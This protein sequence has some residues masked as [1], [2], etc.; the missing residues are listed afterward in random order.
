M[1][2]VNHIAFSF[3][4]ADRIFSDLSFNV[5]SG[6]IVALVGPSGCGKTTL[7]KLIYGLLP[8]TAGHI[9]WKGDRVPHPN[10]V[11][12]P[13]EKT[14]KLVEQDFNLM[15]FINVYENI[16][17]H[18]LHIHD[19]DRQP[20]LDYWLNFLNITEIE[21]KKASDLSG[22]QM[23][24]V[25][26]AKSLTSNPELI[27]L[28]EPFSNLDTLTKSNL[29]SDLKTHLRQT[30]TTAML[31]I[32]Q[33]EDALEIADKIMVLHAGQIQQFAE[34]KTVYKRP[35]TR[36]V[37]ELFGVS[38][39]LNRNEFNAIFNLNAADYHLID[40]AIMVRAHEIRLEDLKSK[41]DVEDTLFLGHRTLQKVRIQGKIIW[42]G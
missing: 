33:P 14:V 20:I 15:P 34:P 39:F 1:L 35:K 22:G 36:M 16:Q 27:L 31:V 21:H 23:Q 2:K 9:S 38:N 17:Q 12:I 30:G 41:Y 25:A 32:H 42:V 26:M 19:D 3:S 7:L 5:Q 6:E 10:E 11:L 13:G 28:D 18:V 24:R 40:E 4:D 8:L 29:M 37:A